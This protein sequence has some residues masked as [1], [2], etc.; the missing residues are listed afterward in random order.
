MTTVG[1]VRVSKEEQTEG[2]SP[3]AQGREIRR[4]ASARN[5]K[6]ARI[7]SDL[8]RSGKTAYRPGF[9]TMIQA[10]DD[11]LVDTIIVH[12]LDRFSRSLIDTLTYLRRLHLKG[13]TLIS[14]TEQFDFSTP[15][16]KMML[17]VIAALAEWFLNNLSQ[18]TSKGKQ[19]RARQ[20]HWNGV[21]TFGYTTIRR[22]QKQLSEDQDQHNV[23]L[24]EDALE[25]WQGR[26]R[27]T[28]AFPCPVNGPGAVLAF[29]QYA[30][31][32]KSYADI[33][34]ALNEA[35]YRTTGHQGTR[36]FSK[37][38]VRPMLTNPF[39]M[40]MTTYKGE[41]MPGAH[42]ALISEDLFERC[43][44]VRV[45]RRDAG[46]KSPKREAQSYPLSGL[47]R[48][49]ECGA[50]FT[51]HHHRNVRRYRGD[52]REQGKECSQYPRSMRSDVIEES[53]A[54]ILRDIQLP[55]DWQARV[56]ARLESTARNESVTQSM[57]RDLEGQLERAK[58]LY[59]WKD[60]TED[61]YRAI[62]ADIESRLPQPERPVA[63]VNLERAA[64]LL[65][66]FRLLLDKIPLDKRGPLFR[67]LF[68]DLYVGNGQIVAVRPTLVLNELLKYGNM[69]D[70][71]YLASSEGLPPTSPP[72]VFDKRQVHSGVIMWVAPNISPGKV[73]KLIMEQV[74]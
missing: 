18:E 9:Q 21:L 50:S 6:V 59:V 39:Y 63:M 74:A 44:Q 68:V 13:A 10:A 22:I 27:D 15:I 67:Q 1:Y 23:D 55:D 12:K 56:L 11:G 2:Y 20:G 34:C 7:Y 14:V 31:G 26:N 24:W 66:D 48:C 32:V 62:K 70:V 30:T 37:G 28:A 46:N 51:G 4:L 17:A 36:L 35:G 8:G 54:R 40:G 71:R 25:T 29:E 61:E 72:G 33:A 53:V 58:H 60:I 3:E 42:E 73:R 16:G 43:Q 57:R 47:L 45:W 38:T 69:E 52:G 65:D 64:Q 5:L 19:E 49:V 41:T